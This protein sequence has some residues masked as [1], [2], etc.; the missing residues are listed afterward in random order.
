V[1]DRILNESAI[2]EHALACSKTFR[3]G[4]F[5]RV[6]QDFL[7]EVRIDVEALIV[8]LRNSHP[9]QLNTPLPLESGFLTGNLGDRVIHEWNNLVGRIIQNKVR[10]QPSVGQTLSRT[11]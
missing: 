7:D 5:T 2:R 10:R 8:T 9:T 11:R 4:K 6:G 3:G 1:S